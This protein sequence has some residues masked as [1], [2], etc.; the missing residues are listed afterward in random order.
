MRPQAYILMGLSL[1][2]GTGLPMT[3]TAKIRSQGEV[4][5]SARAFSPDENAD[6]YDQGLAASFHLDVKAK[7]SGGF[8]QQLRLTGR[9]ASIDGDRSALIVNDAWVGWRN[10]SLQLSVGAETFNWSTAEA[11]HPT[12]TLNSRN[13][14][15][16]VEN[17]EKMGELAAKVRV[18]FLTGG[19]TLVYLPMRVAPRLPGIRSRLNWTQ[20]TALGTTTWA[21]Q[22]GK[23]STGRFAPQYAARLD[24]T[25][26]Q[27]DVT[28]HY[29]AHNERMVPNLLVNPAT[30]ETALVFP[31]VERFGGSVV[32]PL[33]D[34]LFKLEGEYRTYQDINTQPGLILATG[35]TKDHAA[36]A[37]GFDYGWS[38]EAGSEGTLLIEGQVLHAPGTATKDMGLVG[39]FQRDVLLGYRHA[40]NDTEDTQFLVGI[41]AD[42]ERVGECMSTLTG[43]QRLNNDWKLEGKYQF[44]YAPNEASLLY[45]QDGTHAAYVDLIR[46]F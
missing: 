42:V 21:D 34:W 17:P 41:I 37:A 44:I 19:L 7:Q 25:L 39:P 9:A 10:R 43:S 15:S 31:F 4:A 46:S 32:S 36:I 13:L 16:D 14:D 20:G 26:G 27:T 5:L 1:V 45:Q 33:G 30:G 23:T 3:G 11:F 18:R 2:I 28:L 38:Y 22:N 6:I 12:D 24:Q 29:V 40:F 8:R 35:A